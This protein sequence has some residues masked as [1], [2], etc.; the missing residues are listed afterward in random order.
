MTFPLV[1]RFRVLPGGVPD[2]TAHQPKRQPPEL[3]TVPDD[4]AES[5]DPEQAGPVRISIEYRVH[6]EN[7]AE[8]TR[9]I[10]QLKRVR[11]RGGALR[12][13]IYRDATNPTCLN[14]TFIAESWMDYLRSRERATASDERIR[15]QV[16]ALHHGPQ[17]PQISFQVY[18]REIANPT[19]S[20]KH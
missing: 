17:P 3:V 11:M 5:A 18:A 6:V 1:R 4:L 12:W 14:E 7:Y 15:Q 2:T 8:F 10:H 13:G 16:W 19:P 20:L 9:V